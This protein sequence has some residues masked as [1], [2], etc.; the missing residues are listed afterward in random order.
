MPPAANGDV[1]RAV[2][3]APTAIGLVDG[4]FENVPAVWHKEILYALSQGVHVFGAASMGALRAAELSEFGMVG[5]GAIFAAYRDN[6]LEDD[7]EVAVVHGP[8]ELDYLPVSEAMVNVRATV[9]RA[10]SDGHRH[11]ASR[12]RAQAC[13]VDL[14]QGENV[15]P[16]ARA[17]SQR[18]R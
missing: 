6:R 18:Q 15:G 8:A 9:D 7:D 10:V 12:S 4:Y 16:R 3:A 11:G 1:Y 13:Q 5:V 2:S 17:S 14:L